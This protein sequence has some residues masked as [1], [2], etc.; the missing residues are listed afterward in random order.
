MFIEIVLEFS[1]SMLI[2]KFN[3]IHFWCISFFLPI[4]NLNPQKKENCLSPLS[5][6]L[7]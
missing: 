6:Q 3:G 4:P 1:G 7:Q 5:P 2:D